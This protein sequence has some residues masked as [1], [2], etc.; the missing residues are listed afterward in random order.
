MRLLS[1]KL[2]QPPLLFF[3]RQVLRLLPYLPQRIP[4]CLPLKPLSPQVSLQL[5][6]SPL[7]LPHHHRWVL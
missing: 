4:R 3:L 2:F 7:R 5:S 1:F 6:L